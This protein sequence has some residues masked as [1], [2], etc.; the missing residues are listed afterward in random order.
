MTAN[1]IAKLITNLYGTKSASW[2]KYYCFGIRTDERELAVGEEV[3]CSY[4][5]SDDVDYD[6]AE[7]LDGTCA[8]DIS[9]MHW[10]D[11]EDEMDDIIDA[12]KKAL[13]LNNSL[14]YPGK[15]QYLI[16]GESY[17]YGNDDDEV[18]ISNAV[19]VAVIK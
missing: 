2:G 14:R 12:V 18:I 11:I 13:E 5:W 3:P 15:H 9:W 19:V 17:D 8:T 7:Q 6:D 10:T 4:N 1:E 16:A